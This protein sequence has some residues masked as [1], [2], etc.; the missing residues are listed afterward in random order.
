MEQPL[1][2][3]AEKGNLIELSYKGR[4]HLIRRNRG[5]D[6][7]LELVRHPG[8]VYDARSLMQVGQSIPAEYQALAGLDKESLE[9]QG[10]YCHDYSSWLPMSDRRSIGDVIARLKRLVVLEAE[11]RVNNNLAALDDVLQEKQQLQEY[12]GEV[13]KNDGSIRCFPSNEAQA[14]KAVNKALRRCIKGIE[15]LDPELGSH[16]REQVKTWNQV[17]YLGWG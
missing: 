1:Y 7:L 9:L 8:K 3:I 16:F 4:S 10:L 11:M 2:E 14:V 5:W 13:L 6:Y 12:L 15:E 17:M